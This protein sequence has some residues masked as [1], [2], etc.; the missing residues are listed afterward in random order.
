[1]PD[2]LQETLDTFLNDEAGVPFDQLADFA[3]PLFDLYQVD[4]RA[5][6]ANAQ[7]DGRTDELASLVA[8]L[9]TAAAPPTTVSITATATA[10]SFM[11][12]AIPPTGHTRINGERRSDDS[13]RFEAA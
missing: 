11:F 2:S 12:T 8:V 4:M 13:G 7:S 3:E 5:S 10:V 6:L 9:E 1:M